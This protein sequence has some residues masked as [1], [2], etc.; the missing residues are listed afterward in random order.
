[1]DC[2]SNNMI[3]HF[4]CK[5]CQFKLPYVGSTVTKFRFGFNNHKSTHRKFRKKLKKRIIQKI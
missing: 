5:K 4:E 2:N 1:M 3:H